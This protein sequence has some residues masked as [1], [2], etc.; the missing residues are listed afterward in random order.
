MATIKNRQNA[1]CDNDLTQSESIHVFKSDITRDF[2]RKSQHC[3]IRFVSIQNKR[4]G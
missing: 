2:S 1:D 4:S 3:F